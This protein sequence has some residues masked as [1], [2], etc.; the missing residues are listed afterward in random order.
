M[1]KYT[2]LQTIGLFLTSILA[3]S[4]LAT[5]ILANETT[6][7]D[8]PSIHTAVQ[9]YMAE[10]QKNG[11]MKFSKQD[12]AVMQKAAQDLAASMPD[13]GLKIGDKAPLFSLPNA[14]G[15]KISLANYLKKGPVILVFYRGAWC[16]F[17]N[18]QLHALSQS[19]PAFKR[20]R[21]SLIAI[22]PQTPDKSKQQLK[23]TKY[24]F[25]VL[26]DLDSKTMRDYKLYFELP[27]DLIAVYKK[28]GLDI[29]SFN[30]K[31]R[32]VLPVPGTYVIDKSG[33]IRAAFADTDYK[34]RMEPQAILDALKALQK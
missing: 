5:T 12:M 3:T 22:T 29:E 25:N 33:I 6:T 9:A 23:K 10:Q 14:F 8:V 28:L 2:C 7:S 26:S 4:L 30:G 13:P 27:A 32:N 1:K 16:P 11:K 17:C 18:I 20:Y 15:K 19:M 24:P 21:A 34:K 31:G